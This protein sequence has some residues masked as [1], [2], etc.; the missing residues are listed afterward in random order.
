MNTQAETAAP[1]TDKEKLKL[2]IV[3]SLGVVI[4][5]VGAFQFMGGSEPAKKPV[6]KKPA[7]STPAKDVKSEPPVDE[8]KV[9]LARLIAGAY[10]QRDP[11]K[12][13]SIPDEPPAPEQ[14]PVTPDAAKP[15]PVRNPAPAPMGGSIAPV[16]PMAG[17]PAAVPN[18]AIGNPN[19]ALAVQPGVPLRQP[20]EPA[21][22]VAGVVIGKERMVIL[23]DDQ[24]NQIIRRL[25]DR[26]DGSTKITAI[27][28]GAVKVSNGKKTMKLAPVPAEEA[29]P[30]PGT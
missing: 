15:Q 24:G 13:T 16:D 26:L 11:F 22:S 5:G 28:K 19:T 17:L 6:A 29:P 14:P 18:G 4:L 3:I 8:R 10:P 9:E 1:G 27:D 25:G 20:G 2:I 21:Y 30:V 7:E 23:Q 12:P